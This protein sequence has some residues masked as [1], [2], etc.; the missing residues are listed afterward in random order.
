MK[1]AVIKYCQSCGIVFTYQVPRCAI[2]LPV[3]WQRAE[4]APVVALDALA[5]HSAQGLEGHICCAAQTTGLTCQ[6]YPLATDDN[7]IGSLMQGLAVASRVV[8]FP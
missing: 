7:T 2:A 4:G 8:H 3:S 5:L 6:S 1:T